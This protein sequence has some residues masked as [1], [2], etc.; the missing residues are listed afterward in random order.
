M[1]ARQRRRRGA[2]P[3]RSI[4]PLWERVVCAL[5]GG[6]ASVEA[7]RQASALMPPGHPLELVTVVREVAL[8]DRWGR[9]YALSAGN[10]SHVFEP[11]LEALGSARRVEAEPIFE[12]GPPA[13]ALVAELRRRRATLVALGSPRHHRLPAVVNDLVHGSVVA[14]L[15]HEAPCSILIARADHGRSRP[16]RT[17]AAGFDASPEADIVLQTAEALAAR[18]G[19]RLTVVV[20]NGA[21]PPGKTTAAVHEDVRAPVEALTSL[22]ADLLVLG[23]RGLHGLHALG[24]VSERVAETSDTSVLVIRA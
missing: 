14:H 23:S 12:A 20:A 9:G 21:K 4:P 15:L 8:D 19:A 13:A 2:P 22:S 3:A 24:S 1:E 5:D 6:D 16:F 17:M 10:W 11:A 7:A 18:V